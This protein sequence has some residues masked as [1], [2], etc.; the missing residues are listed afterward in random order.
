MNASAPR[1]TAATPPLPAAPIGAI[2][3]PTPADKAPA[4][5]SAPPPRFA[6]LLRQ[7]R[8]EAAAS[9]EPPPASTAPPLPSATPGADGAASEATAAT[10]PNGRATPAGNAA[11]ARAA[12]KDADAA[13]RQAEGADRAD[14]RARGAADDADDGG[15]G[16]HDAARSTPSSSDRFD[17]GAAATLAAQDGARAFASATGHGRSGARGDDASDDGDPAA[18]GAVDGASRHGEGHGRV[19]AA[20]DTAAERRAT[21]VAA[22]GEAAREAAAA[23]A[24]Q[25]AIAEGARASLD[26]AL[27]TPRPRERAVESVA[28]AWALGSATPAGHDTP[29]VV[30]TPQLAMATPI[31]SP[32]FGATLGVHVSVLAKDGVQHAE[33]HL[34]PTEMGP[35]SIHIALD[36]QA[37]RIDFGAD[38]AA[39]RHAIE[40]GLPELASA[41]Q[42]AGFTLAGGG[43]SQHAGQR[44]GGDDA[45]AARALRVDAGTAPPS[46]A[47]MA[48][49]AAGSAQRIAAGGVDLYA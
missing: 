13:T 36:G 41:L 33:L 30:A 10:T 28:S 29:V 35:V 26:A 2:A 15:D 42:D 25:S 16:E 46:I 34:N 3:P 1:A 18:S 9:A 4:P 24:L 49:A 48:T 44:P 6:E 23:P 5:A 47:S 37:A 40:R 19:V 39:T 14:G 22:G 11:K 43:V 20:I 27:A 21:I 12:A 32:D 38:V 17:A 8:A 45:G 31:D 7:S